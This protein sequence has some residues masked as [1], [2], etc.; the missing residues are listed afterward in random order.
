MLLSRS[1]NRRITHTII[2]LSYTHG[3]Q[4]EK[5]KKQHDEGKRKRAA[6]KI[7]LENGGEKYTQI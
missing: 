2:Y 6:D 3:L 1:Q 5:E 4:H 7:K